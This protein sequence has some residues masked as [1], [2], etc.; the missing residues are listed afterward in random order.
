MARGRFISHT[1]GESHKFARLANDTHRLLYVLL[2]THTDVNGRVDADPVWIKGK[3]T[4]RLPITDT[5][6]LDALR[7]MHRV[8]LITH[9]RVRGNPYLEVTNF[10]QHNKVRAEREARPTIPGPEEGVLDP[11]PPTPEEVRSNSGVSPAQVQVEVQVQDQVEE[12]TSSPKATV[13]ENHQAFLEA[14]NDNRGTL[15]AVTTLNAKRKSMIAALVKEH[16]AVDAV[17]LLADAAK[18]VAADDYWVQKQYGFD[19]LLRPGRVLEKAEKW[20]AGGVQLG[21]ANLKLTTQVASWARA[22]EEVN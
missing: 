16:G 18:A 1:L 5:Q 4:T 15:P 9:Y 13:G 6:I 7:D 21:E 17:H 3:V 14:W 2:I 10:T 22:L 20:R 8:G 12:T 19:N 11:S